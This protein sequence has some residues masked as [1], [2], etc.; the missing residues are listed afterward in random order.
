MEYW[1]LDGGILDCGFW[2]WGL[3]D[4]VAGLGPRVQGVFKVE[5]AGPTHYYP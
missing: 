1:R 4:G 3:R 2:D 5:A